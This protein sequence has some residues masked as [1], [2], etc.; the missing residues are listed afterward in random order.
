MV[1]LIMGVSGSGKTSV[2]KVLAKSFSISFYDAD[3]Y[4]NKKNIEKMKKGISLNDIDRKPWLDSLALKIKEWNILGDSVLACSALKEDYRLILSKNN[5]I[6]YIFL[7]G[8]YELIYK[9]LSQRKNQKHSLQLLI[10]NQM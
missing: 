2:G 4:H 8:D 7:E 1:Y 3:D 5:E 9:R 10:T 6:T